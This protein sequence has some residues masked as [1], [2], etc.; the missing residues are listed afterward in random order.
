MDR[1]RSNPVD[2]FFVDLDD[3]APHYPLHHTHV[4]R[5]HGTPPT[6]D[7]LAAHLAARLH[8]VPELRFRPGVPHGRWERSAELDLGQGQG[9]GQGLGLESRPEPG[10]GADLDRQDPEPD[11]QDPEPDRRGREPEPTA[12]TRAAAH[13]RIV[14]LDRGAP[15]G[16]VPLLDAPPLDPAPPLPDPDEGF[17]LAAQTLLEASL[18]PLGPVW[19]VWLLYGYTPGEFA[20][21]YRAHHAFQDAG[22]AGETTRRL[23]GPLDAEPMAAV[24]GGPRPRRP[25]V[26]A[27]VPRVVADLITPRVRTRRAFAAAADAH[28][29][30]VAVSEPV[31]LDYLRKIGE[32]H[33]A[34][35]NQVYLAGLC[36]A[37]A[38]VFTAVDPHV[39]VPMSTALP[40]EEGAALGN[41]LSMLRV[42]LPCSESSLRR[43]IELIRRRTASAR[44]P[45]RRACTSAMIRLCPD[46][47]ARWTVRNYL[48]PRRTQLVASNRALPDGLSFDGNP[49]HTALFVPPLIPGHRGFSFF[50]T[51]GRKARLA[52]VFPAASA[53]WQAVPERWL[54]SL[55]ELATLG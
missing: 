17:A 29:T 18:S 26:L 33:D 55:E 5:F 25:A 51:F 21:A 30:R 40:G 23:F 1:L 13:L 22:A 15:L 12:D 32:M 9:R 28:G 14:C 11:R 27:H 16:A 44:K 48:Q 46:P 53:N 52:V 34:S 54:E 4:L 42:Q 37:L 38:D 31:D 6:R 45:E 20:L 8:L 39:C 19:D 43:R 2:Q 10:L 47:L 3:A 24:G 49:A 36:G 7:R 41:R 50:S 35:V